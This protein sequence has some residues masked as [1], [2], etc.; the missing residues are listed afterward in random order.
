[1]I[2]IRYQKT[3][4]FVNIVQIF[5]ASDTKK[6]S[7]DQLLQWTHAT[8][9]SGRS[10][11]LKHIDVLLQQGPLTCPEAAPVYCTSRIAQCLTLVRIT[12][13]SVWLNSIRLVGKQLSLTA[14]TE[15]R[16]RVLES[17]AVSNRLATGQ[18]YEVFPWFYSTPP[19]KCR[20]VSQRRSR[21]YL[22]HLIIISN[23]DI[24]R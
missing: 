2:A 3:S 17:A 18:L 11:G 12:L 4:V 1:M 16:G 21:P 14:S 22:F 5:A 23:N 9:Y 8:S 24:R 15:L 10:N 20:D 6:V 19:G 13:S 7:K